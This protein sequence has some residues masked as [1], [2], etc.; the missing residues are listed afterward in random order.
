MNSQIKQHLMDFNP[1]YKSPEFWLEKLPDPDKTLLSLEEIQT[2]NNQLATTFTPTANPLDLEHLSKGE[3][4]NYIESTGSLP[5]RVYFQGNILSEELRKQLE[6][7]QNRTNV[8]SYTG[9]LYGLTVRRTS[10]RAY[11][12]DW[13]ITEEE[14]DLEF[15]LLQH[16]SIDTAT[17]LAILHSSVDKEWYFCLVPYYFGWVRRKDVATSSNKLDIVDYVE[18]SN[19]VIVTDSW[20][21]LPIQ[22]EVLL[23]QMGSR[24]TYTN[25]S[26][27]KLVLK[28]PIK[29]KEGELSWYLAELEDYANKVSFG[30][31]PY[32]MKNIFKQAFK[33]L[34]E[35]YAW[36]DLRQGQPGRDCS[37]FI[38]DIFKVVGIL[39]PRDSTPQCSVLPNLSNFNQIGSYETRRQEMI[40]VDP[41]G[42]VLC[43]P[44]HIML[45]LGHDK[46]LP[47]AIHCLW[48]YS[49]GSN[50]SAQDEIII[51]NK[52]VVT[53]L[54][55][56]MGSKRGTFLERLSSVRQVTL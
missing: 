56:G 17:P 34:D 9:N 29:T 47:F 49:F 23:F 7:G 15:D 45:Y 32:T 19:C 40:A 16:L 5:N 11:P 36:G 2:L 13:I 37:R 39:L 43:M 54:N 22:D 3:I 12:S 14:N 28:I 25:R 20:F 6:T 50:K 10:V 48:A 42:I 27:S 53:S 26:G 51:L 24:L 33:M 55:I 35:P 44:G 38:Q 1:E 52:V 46:E 4:G 21:R 31:L 41:K 8:A 30:Y 18:D